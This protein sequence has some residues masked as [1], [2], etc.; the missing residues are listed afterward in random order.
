MMGN[1]FVAGRTPLSKSGSKLGK[2]T[3]LG[4]HKGN[5]LK[6][7][8]GSHVHG[9]S[10]SLNIDDSRGEGKRNQPARNKA[11]HV[12]ILEVS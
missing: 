3:R 12:A 1:K 2:L 9:S 11:R 8:F 10:H 4:S 5:S 6:N 7:V